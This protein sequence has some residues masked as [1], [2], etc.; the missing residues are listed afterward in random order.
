MTRS[1]TIFKRLQTQIEGG[2]LKAGE[3]L[4]SVR[5]ASAEY[6]VSK[7]TVAEAYDR[8]VALGLIHARQ[9]SGYFVASGRHVMTS[10]PSPHVAEAID[11]ASLLREQLIQ[12]YAVRVGDGRPP[13]SWMERLDFGR[14]LSQLKSSQG[15]DSGHGYSNPWGYLPLRERIAMTLAERGIH[16]SPDQILLTYGANHALDLV[17]RQLLEPGDVVLVDNPGYY[18]LFG[19]LKLSRIRTVGIRRRD[20]GP[21]LDDL[22][23][24]CIAL[25]P[26][27]FFT[28]SLA[29]N[30]TGSAISLPVAHRLLQIAEQYGFFIVEDDAFA[31]ILTATTARL[32]TFDQLRRVLYIGTFSKTLSAS[33]RVGFVVAE[34][35]LV[36]TLCDLKMLTV[37]NSSDILERVV[38]NMIATGQYLKHLRRLKQHVEHATLEALTALQAAGLRTPF[39]SSGGYYVWGELPRH[40]DEMDL[41]R[42]AATEGIFLAPGSIFRP[43]RTRDDTAAIRVNIAYAD[44]P[45][46]VD[47]MRR[48]L[49]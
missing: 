29:H 23:E 4:L 12:H 33:L 20:D 48:E 45:A 3:R 32:A 41:A 46:F 39:T 30:P 11:T 14:Q 1:E 17:A 40:V 36:T 8:L 16:A 43:E 21:D 5:A 47:F 18:P 22:V 6:Q 44:T 9:G 49:A 25:R 24:K 26:K 2:L 35:R 34:P 38:F 42:K 28:Q 19:K 7:N 10:D 31:D 37:V 13:A 27:V 15:W